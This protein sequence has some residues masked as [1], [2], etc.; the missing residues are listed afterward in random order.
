M[1]VADVRPP[2]PAALPKVVRLFGVVGPEG[3]VTLL[4]PRP[5]AEK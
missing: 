5:P 2:P 4:R 1:K 3:R